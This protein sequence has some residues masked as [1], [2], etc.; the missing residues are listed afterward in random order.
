MLDWGKGNL[1]NHKLFLI[2]L[3]T[4]YMKQLE[5]KISS[6]WKPQEI[7][8]KNI[9]EKI[10]KQWCGNSRLSKKTSGKKLQ[11]M[12]Q[13]LETNE[14]FYKHKRRHEDNA[15]ILK[16]KKTHCEKYNQQI[17]KESSTWFWTMIPCVKCAYFFK[18]H[19]FKERRLKIE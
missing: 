18:N 12:L 14:E 2:T 7:R 3:S 8:N 15:G 9:G 13:Y 10:L 6:I 5:E 4:K 1:T 17:E 16:F 11:N 19:P